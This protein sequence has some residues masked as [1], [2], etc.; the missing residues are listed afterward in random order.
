MPAASVAVPPAMEMDKVP[1]PSMFD[2]VTVRDVVPA[3]ETPT[4]PDALPVVFND[5][6]GTASVIAFAPVYVIVNSTGPGLVISANDGA[7][8]E[9]VGGV[10]S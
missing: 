2:S 1:I 5:M 3:P 9:I 7:P 8:M 4:V 6:S 10:V